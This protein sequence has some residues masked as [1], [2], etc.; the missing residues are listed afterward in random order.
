MMPVIVPLWVASDTLVVRALMRGMMWPSWRVR[1]LRFAS[2]LCW[3]SW[4]GLCTPACVGFL[5]GRSAVW[6]EVGQEEAWWRVGCGRSPHVA[7]A[8]R[9]V[10]AVP[11]ACMVYHSS[12]WRW[13]MRKLGA[14]SSYTCVVQGGWRVTVILGASFLRVV[15]WGMM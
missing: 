8:Y 5:L 13:V 7:H 6:K 10:V 1:A 11:T 14:V 12:C 4:A 9:V 15:V 3:A 2:C